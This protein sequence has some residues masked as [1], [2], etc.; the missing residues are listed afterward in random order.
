MLSNRYPATGGGDCHRYY[1]CFLYCHCYG[2]CDLPSHLQMVRQTWQGQQI[3]WWM[4]NHWNKKRRP[5]GCIR[6]TFRGVVL[7]HRTILF[8]FAYWHYSICKSEIQYTSYPQSMFFPLFDIKSARKFGTYCQ[9]GKKSPPA[10]L[11]YLIG[12]KYIFCKIVF[13]LFTSSRSLLLPAS[14]SMFSQEPQKPE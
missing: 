7:C 14:P 3:A 9:E 10:G 6:G 4:L 12:G 11:I 13:P 2:R 5:L 8:P 1:S